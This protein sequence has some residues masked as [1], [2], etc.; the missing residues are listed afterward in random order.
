VYF[1]AKGSRARI[2]FPAMHITLYFIALIVWTPSLHFGWND[3]DSAY[4]IPNGSSWLESGLVSAYQIVRL[5][6]YRV[7]Q[8]LVPLLYKSVFD[9]CTSA[10]KVRLREYIF[11]P[12]NFVFYSP[13]CWNSFLI[14]FY[15]QRSKNVQQRGSISMY[16]STYWLICCRNC[17]KSGKIRML[18]VKWSWR[19]EA[20]DQK[21][22]IKQLK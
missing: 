13:N 10:P 6:K 11:Q 2:Y 15:E 22:W 1:L 17:W 3:S 19:N 5:S 12:H 21:S 7:S 20:E 18:V 4:N 16:T 14:L 9:L 8:K